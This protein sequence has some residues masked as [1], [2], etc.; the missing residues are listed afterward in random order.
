[1]IRPMRRLPA[2]LITLI[3]C[4]LGVV[5]AANASVQLASTAYTVSENQGQATIEV[6][7]STPLGGDEF[8]RYGTHRL[9]SLPGID[10]HDVGGTLHFGSGQRS[11]TFT[12]PIIPHDFIGP[13]AHVAVY[14]YGSWPFTLGD[15]NNARLAIVHDA[16]LA[17]RDPQNPL[18]L[19]PA[20][21][22]GNLLQG[23]RFYVDR[24]GSPA[25]HAELSLRHARP[26][27]LGALSVIASQPWTVRFGGWNGPDPGQAVFVSLEKSY[28]ADPGA[29]P[30]ISTY[31]LA[32]GQCAR[33]G[34]ADTSGQ[35]AA[36]R[37][38]VD[39]LSYGIGNFRAVLF[40]EIDSLITS[41][42]LHPQA[43]GVRLAELR[44]AIKTLELNPHLLVYV[45]AGA[46]DALG[47]QKTAGLLAG[48][49]VHQAQGFFLN[50]TH[51]DWTT[52][53]LAYGQRIARALGGVHFV[54]NTGT[55]GRGPLLPYDRVHQGNEVLC[56]P[57]GRGLGPRATT[58]TGYMWADAF[59]WTT[60]P[61]ESGG[62]CVR[63]A[64]PTGT[65][66]P[67]YAV[68]LARLADFNVTGPGKRYLARQ[69]G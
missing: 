66:W 42:C 50:S 30:L 48:E 67:A 22:K 33:G 35:Q 28:L 17:T 5:A 4:Q 46:A 57:S 3:L 62:Q 41:P 56:N 19:D 39:G 32:S 63:G 69:R 61:G 16:L 36:Y 54:V 11:A 10:Y 6:T 1:M 52:S 53:E 15:P 26:S 38:F 25:G 60:N 14:L 8:V 21:R 2:T 9:D 34:S 20:P 65:Y 64:T 59:A 29:V 49:G 23:A 47:W 58:N 31:R 68:G 55:N 51:F 44:Y 27:W 40:L 24:W 12:I 7:R 13:P 43:L 45:D 37:R 18:Q